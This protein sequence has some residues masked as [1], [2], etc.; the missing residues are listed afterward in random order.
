ME[1]LI[2]V[3]VVVVI[4]LLWVI[5]IYNG[6][7]QRR[8]HCD[9]SWSGVDTELKR[10]YDLIP[11]LVEAVKGYAAHEKDVLERVIRARN[12]AAANHG[13][14]DS[15]AHDENALV[16][17]LRQLFALAERYPVLKADRNFLH[18]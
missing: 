10:R 12:T 6:L 1:L 14:T 2:F 5:V 4:P 8:N 17:G 18:L 9:E 7:V 13:T 11:N 15:Q 16:G 3:G